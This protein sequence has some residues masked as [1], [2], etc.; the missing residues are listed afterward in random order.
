VAISHVKEALEVGKELCVLVSARAL[1]IENH[2]LASPPR[3]GRSDRKG[4][5][6]LCDSGCTPEDS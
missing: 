6:P 5:S 2:W 4:S 3:I 1:E